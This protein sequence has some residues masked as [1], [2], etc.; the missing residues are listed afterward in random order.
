MKETTANLRGSLADHQG[1]LTQ[2]AAVLKDYNG[3]FDGL[4]KQIEAVLRSIQRGVQD[5]NQAIEA[6]FRGS[7]DHRQRGFAADRPDPQHAN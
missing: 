6:N 1:L 2:H 4:D 3:T 5:Y 7:S